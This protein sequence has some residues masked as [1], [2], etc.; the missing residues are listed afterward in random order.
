[1]PSPVSPA[2]TLVERIDAFGARPA[3][4]D[5]KGLWTYEA[6]AA[7]SVG[8]APGLLDPVT[9]QRGGQVVLLCT[10]GADFVSGLLAVWRVGAMAVPLHPGYPVPELAALAADAEAR[11]VLASPEH[12]PTAEAVAA[13]VGA[14]LVVLDAPSPDDVSTDRDRDGGHPI[15]PLADTSPALMV[16]T[17]GTTGRPKGV[18]HTH[19]SLRAQIVA[20]VEAWD[21]SPDDR[22][23]QVLPLHH[24]HGI[25]NVTLCPLWVGAVGE[26]A[27]GLDPVATWERLASGEITVFMAVPTIYARL[28]AA[29]DAAD[30]GTRTRWS[31][32]AAGL[33]LM[34][35]GS[36]ALPVTVLD[37]WRDL[38]SH[39][40]LERYGMTEVG[41]ALGNTLERRVPGHVGV[42]F[43]GV[44]VRLVDDAGHD[45]PDGSPGEMLLRGPQVFAEYWRR[46]EATSECFVDGWFRTGDVAELTPGGYR[47][48]GR[49]SVDILK[50]GG[51]KVSALEIEAEYRTHPSIADCAVV[52]LPDPEWGDRVAMAVVAADG[53]TPAADELRAWGKERLAPAKVP[54]AYLIVDDL[55]RNAMGKV[56]KP[57]VRD[58][59]TGHA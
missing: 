46:P 30:E 44:E 49:S 26:A 27:G 5:R 29:W 59:F 10:P 56:V 42:P 32:G 1:V 28:V 9:G 51:E 33:R 34:V 37:R 3:V 25:V 13:E 16:F 11:V 6:L 14:H 15:E 4:V 17:S 24:V 43:R 7:R 52:G 12:R 23:L 18:V 38:T 57:E 54:V 22:I 41:M 50:S 47:L 36:A 53:T 55:P 8:I 19:A 45:V 21:W 35:S 31:E 2:P 58:L 20:M 40:L 48:L 39:V